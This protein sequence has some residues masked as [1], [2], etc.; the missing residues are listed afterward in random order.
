MN[1]QLPSFSCDGVAAGNYAATFGLLNLA[2]PAVSVQPTLQRCMLSD[3]RAASACP[4]RLR[5]LL[6]DAD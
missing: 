5:A 2:A 4:L 6:A 3:Q 1:V